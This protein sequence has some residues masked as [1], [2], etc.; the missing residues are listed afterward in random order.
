MSSK[1][2]LLFAFSSSRKRPA[3]DVRFLAVFELFLSPNG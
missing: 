2:P 3:F 1:I